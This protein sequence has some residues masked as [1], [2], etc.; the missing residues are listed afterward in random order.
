MKF[1]ELDNEAK[2]FDI[3]D[4][5]NGW[6]ETHNDNDFFSIAEAKS[7]LAQEEWEYNSEGWLLEVDE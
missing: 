6:L 3:K 2:N 4:Y 7:I 1:N 5:I